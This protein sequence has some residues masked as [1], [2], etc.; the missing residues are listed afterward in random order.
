MIFIGQFIRTTVTF[1]EDMRIFNIETYGKTIA[2]MIFQIPQHNV[3]IGK[4]L[5]SGFLNRLSNQ[6]LHQPLLVAA[7]NAMIIAITSV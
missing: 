5:Q 6:T 1:L 2:P 3:M 7:S 4:S